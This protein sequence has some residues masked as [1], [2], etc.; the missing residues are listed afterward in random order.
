MFDDMD[1]VGAFLC[2]SFTLYL[3]YTLP[4]CQNWLPA[5]LRTIPLCQLM[6]VVNKILGPWL[7]CSITLI[8]YNWLCIE[9]KQ[10]DCI[11]V[12]FNLYMED[13]LLG[14]SYYAPTLSYMYVAFPCKLKILYDKKVRYNN[15]KYSSSEISLKLNKCLNK[16][17][18]NILKISFTLYRRH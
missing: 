17:L 4:A 15:F 8:P 13:R 5:K 16:D 10:I 11:F 9:N 1:M 6:S 2:I 7:I 14:L 12:H 18:I 3:A